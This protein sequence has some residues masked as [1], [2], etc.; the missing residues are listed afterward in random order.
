M[1]VSACASPPSSPELLAQCTKLY[2]FW[3]RYEPDPVSFHS[4]QR[5]QAELALVDCQKGRYKTG[6]GT[7]KA[8]LSRSG[9]RFGG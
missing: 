6:V 7:L 4:R 2:E 8:R 3:I 5:V 9:F 1:L